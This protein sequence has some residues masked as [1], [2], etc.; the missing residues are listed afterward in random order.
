MKRMLCLVSIVILLFFLL[1]PPVLR[2]FATFDVY[3]KIE[4]K[5]NN[6]SISVIN[7]KRDDEQ[8]NTSYLNN[9]PYN[10]QYKIKGN[11]EEVEL[12]NEIIDNLKQYGKISFNKE[13][14]I[15]ELKVDLST[16]SKI[17]EEL[18]NYTQDINKEITYYENLNF[19]C[20]G[21]TL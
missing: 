14:D 1:L 11:Y 10:L 15:T 17:P 13:K 5:G 16:I 21:M 6:D 20:T 9:K 4:A 8:I 12:E 18:I 7:C 19:T 3:E 2:R